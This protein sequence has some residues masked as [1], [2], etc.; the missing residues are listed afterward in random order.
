[1][2]YYEFNA[3]LLSSTEKAYAIPTGQYYRKN[4]ICDDGIIRSL[5]Y[6]VC[7]YVPKTQCKVIGPKTYLKAW[8]VSK[9]NLWNLV[10]EGIDL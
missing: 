10:G 6:P 3:D 4:E 7:K 5:E 9:N 8:L 1:M 2:K